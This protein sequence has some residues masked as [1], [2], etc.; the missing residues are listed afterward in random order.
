LAVQCPKC[1]TE[2]ADTLK[3]CGECGTPLSSPE[4]PQFS[5]TLTL[6]TKAGALIRGQVLAGRY[7]ILEPLGEGG[8]GAVYRVYDRKLEEEVALKLIRP[9]IAADR[10]AIER[11][12]NEIKI[13]R[14]ITHKNVCRMHDLGEAEGISF[15]TMEYVRG[16]DLKSLLHRTKT[17]P[18]GTALSIA[19]QVADGLSEAHGMG[20]VHRDLKP[21]NIMIDKDGNAKIMDFGIARSLLSK[22]LTGEGTI[23]GTPEYMSPEQV[24]GK[25]ADARSDLYT[26]GIILFEMVTGQTPF[27]GDTPLSI[28][29]KHRYEP[30]PDPRTL[31][32]QVPAGLSQFILRCLEKEEARRFQS[33]EEFVSEL[34]RTA[35]ALP[36]AERAAPLKRSLTSREV[37][38]K[39]GVRRALFL[40]AALV[41]LV[42]LA[43]VL[44]R[45]LG[46]GKPPAIPAGP[47]SLAVMYFNNNTGDP[48]LDYL[49]T[50]LADA[51]T[52]DLNQS[53]FI[54]VLSRETLVQILRDMDQLDARSFSADVLRRVASQGR[55]NHLL[56]GDYAKAGDVIRIHLALQDAGSGKTVAS[57]M[58][59]GKGVDSIFGLVDE[60]TK[61]V[62]ADLNLS[63]KQISTD[64]D[65]NVGEI[66]TQNLEA[67]KYYLEGMRNHDRNETR[68]SIALYEQALKLD[69]E[70]VMAYRALA[71]AYLNL[72]LEETGEKYLKKALE[73]KDRFSDRERY[74]L[75]GDAYYNSERTFPQAIEMYSKL[76]ELYPQARSANHMLGNIYYFIEDWDG[77]IRY[78]EIGVNNKTAFFSSYEY[79]SMAYRAKGMFDRAF[80]ALQGYIKNVGDDALVHFGLAHYHICRGE[81]EEAGRELDKALSLNPTHFYNSYYRGVTALF[82]EKWEN[83]ESEFGN[84]LSDKEPEAW[85]RGGYGVYAL[86]LLR[87]KAGAAAAIAAGSVERCREIGVKWAEAEAHNMLSYADLLSG[88]ADESFKEAEAARTCAAEAERPELERAALHYRGL[89]EAAKKS[90]GE[91]RRTADELK[92]R[93]DMSI[94]KK[95]MRRYEHLVGMIALGEGRPR[96]AVSHFERA[97]AELAFPSS[98][99]TDDHLILDAFYSEPLAEAYYLSGDMDNARRTYEKITGLTIGRYLYGDRYARSF[100]RLGLIAEK[101]GDGMRA[102]EHY[103]KFLDLWKDADPGQPDVEDAK[104]RLAGLH[105]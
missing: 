105:G 31:N 96:E 23:I 43:A 67:Y 78:Y 46:R 80:E 27:E 38:V 89:A 9:D 26:L 70:F 93:V 52:A 86:S 15:I 60:L 91:A 88:K 16:E 21:G 62:R 57:E 19:R 33:A 28:A 10:R 72:G 82:L 55:V 99:Y 41:A 77:A 83:A 6:E 12:Q 44:W 101:Q 32:P 24:E 25:P 3:F 47:P 61:K 40:A 48:D 87:G 14:K 104:T 64:I 68:Q 5:K 79:L 63:A 22:G 34:N 97:V 71:M 69:P 103:R 53:R 29:H 49:R 37:T 54:E 50:M 18:V 59:E 100:Y 45:L 1:Q 8:M 58:A 11:F 36:T 65:R 76:L 13:S 98:L 39:F 42:A 17:L 30:A 4:G 66:T 92:R 2:N 20:V 35:T 75:A 102:A 90:F 95:D 7:E 84:I 85:Y 94:Y 56:V 73:F 74:Q 81:F 51:F